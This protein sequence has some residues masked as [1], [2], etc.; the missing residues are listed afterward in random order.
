MRPAACTASGMHGIACA[1]ANTPAT[2]RQ[3]LQHA[4]LVVGHLQRHQRRPDTVPRHRL[5]Q[6]PLQP[7]QGHDAV[8]ID[9]NALDPAGRKAVPREDS[10]RVRARRTARKR[11]ASRSQSRRSSRLLAS[12]PPL[13]KTTSAGLAPDQRG[14]L[15]ARVLD[16]RA[17][18]APF[19]MG[20]GRI[21]DAHRAPPA[22]RRAPR[23]A[24]APSRSSRDMCAP[25]SFLPQSARRLE[26]AGRLHRLLGRRDA[27]DHVL[28]ASCC[29]GTCDL[30]A[31]RVPETVRQAALARPCRALPPR[32][33]SASCAMSS[34]T[35]AMIS[36]TLMLRWP[37]GP[38]GSRPS[39]RARSRPARHA[40]A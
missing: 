11:P 7:C 39:V 13:V 25:S 20:R 17:R 28:Q 1:A 30:L 33:G 16:E 21:A 23:G 26:A 32:R 38:G 36:A 22:W 37:A 18:A 8:A 14:N 3:R 15:L 19:G 34:S 4:G 2:R 27:V 31:Q 10:T 6:A 29:P 12:V 5:S 40:A 9:G 35:A 24:A